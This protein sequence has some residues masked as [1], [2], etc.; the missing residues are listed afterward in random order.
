MGTPSSLG[1]VVSIEIPLNRI[2]CIQAIAMNNEKS[3]ILMKVTLTPQSSD[4]SWDCRSIK[5]EDIPQLAVLMI[6]AYRGTI[7]YQDETLED[8]LQEVRETFEGKNGVLLQECSS[9]LEKNGQ[10]LSACL[11]TFYQPLN[12]PLVAYMMTHPRYK[13]QGMGMHVLKT[14]MNALIEEGYTELCLFV[15]Q[16]NQPAYTLYEGMGFSRWDE[17]IY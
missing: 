2:S 10:A 16:G 17:K 3:R 11:I 12:R 14:S 1:E 6:E 5:Q 13:N 4:R 15:T 9:L 7:D 8:A